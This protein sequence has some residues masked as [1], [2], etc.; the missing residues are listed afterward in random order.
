MLYDRLCCSVTGSSRRRGHLSLRAVPPGLGPGE[1]PRPAVAAQVHALCLRGRP[2]LSR[3]AEGGPH[4]HLPAPAF[5]A[6][7]GIVRK[8]ATERRKPPD[9][10]K[11]P[12]VPA[13]K[14]A[15][16]AHL[17]IPVWDSGG[18]EG[19]PR[20]DLGVAGEVKMASRLCTVLG[21]L[22]CRTVGVVGEVI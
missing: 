18:G 9:S 10:W 21:Y 11:R 8:A 2:W 12:V 6:G 22:G 5:C 17:C 16:S 15:L 4:A 14:R 20:S 1:P 13:R 19:G 7:V 3:A